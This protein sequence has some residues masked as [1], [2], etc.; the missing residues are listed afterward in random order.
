MNLLFVSTYDMVWAAG[1]RRTSPGSLAIP[2]R[3]RG[4][5]VYESVYPK[6]PFYLPFTSEYTK[7]VHHISWPPTTRTVSSDSCVIHRH[8]FGP[9][10]ICV[11]GL[12]SMVWASVV[13]MGYIGV[14]RTITTAFLKCGLS[15]VLGPSPPTLEHDRA[16]ISPS[17]AR[18][19]FSDFVGRKWVIT[20]AKSVKRRW[21][22]AIVWL[23]GTKIVGGGRCQL[24]VRLRRFKARIGH[25]VTNGIGISSTLAA[26][27]DGVRYLRACPSTVSPVQPAKSHTVI[28][29]IKFS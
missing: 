9:D 15:I 11:L 26:R 21:R 3:V 1:V 13:A 19:G 16:S 18:T 8:A 12:W 28:R 6:W 5:F 4:T 10:A 22:R 24:L 14:T 29:M 27:E 2:S 25:K 7:I 20:M 23:P 17:S